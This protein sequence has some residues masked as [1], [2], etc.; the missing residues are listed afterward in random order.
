MENTGITQRKI[1]K[2]SVILPKQQEYFLSN[3]AA[4]AITVTGANF[5][6]SGRSRSTKHKIQ[7]FVSPPPPP[8]FFY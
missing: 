2:Y 6:M 8:N 3:A 1:T 5:S 4:V 7:W